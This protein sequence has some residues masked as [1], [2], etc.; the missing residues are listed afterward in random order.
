MEISE[1]LLSPAED[2]TSELT[3]IYVKYQTCRAERQ[4]CYAVVWIKKSTL[5]QVAMALPETA[6]SERFHPI[7]IDRK[8]ANMTAYFTVTATDPVPSEL[9]DWARIAYETILKTA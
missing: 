8:Y 3:T 6:K 5:I 1:K 4:L 2:C 9:S 7:P